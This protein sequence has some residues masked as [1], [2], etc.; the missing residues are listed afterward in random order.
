[1]LEPGVQ[2]AV[3][4][5]WHPALQAMAFDANRDLGSRTSRRTRIVLVEDDPEIGM[6]YRLQLE[7]DGYE[8]HHATDGRDGLAL[9]RS[10]KPDLVL[11]D[12]RLPGFDGFEILARVRADS[13]L[14]SVPLVIVSNFGDPDMIRKARELGALDYVVKSRT[15]P[16][17]LSQRIPSWVRGDAS[18]Q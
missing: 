12:L 8:I 18:L 9:I 16:D 10:L 2:S 3:R 1:M 7:S 13:Q 14:S 11:C 6:M 17:S 5:I 4:P 15:L